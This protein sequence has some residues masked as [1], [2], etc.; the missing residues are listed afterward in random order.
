MLYTFV[1]SSHF[2][3][4]VMM[5][6]KM[7][8]MFLYKIMLN[9]FTHPQVSAFLNL[10]SEYTQIMVSAENHVVFFLTVS[11]YLSFHYSGL[12]FLSVYSCISLAYCGYIY[13]T[14]RN[15]VKFRRCVYPNNLS[16]YSRTSWIKEIVH[17]FFYTFESQWGPA[18]V[19]LP[20][21]KVSSLMFNRRNLNRFGT[22]E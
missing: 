4:Q 19:W 8:N 2:P 12:I 3:N 17:P 22:T 13:D 11:A 20:F 14:E 21:F 16:V 5:H 1:S 7:Q 15:Y 18:A 10:H 9:T 6:R